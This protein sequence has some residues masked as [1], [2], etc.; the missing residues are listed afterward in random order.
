MSSVMSVRPSVCPHGTT[1]LRLNAFSSNLIHKH[2]FKKRKS[3]KFKFHQN[4]TIITGTLHEDRCTFVIISRSFLLRMRNVSDKSCRKNQNTHFV[5]SNYFLS[6]NRVFYR[7]NLVKYCR[8]GQSRDENM[9][10][11]HCTPDT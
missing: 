7:D 2:F 8:P 3:R 4:L 1:T 6:E 10:H 11:G 5:F 9:A